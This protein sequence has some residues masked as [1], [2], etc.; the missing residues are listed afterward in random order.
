MPTPAGGAGL[1]KA[2]PMS[3][4]DPGLP[5][6]VSISPAKLWVAAGPTVKSKIPLFTGPP[7]SSVWRRA[8]LTSVACTSVVRKTTFLTLSR[9]YLSSCWRWAS[10]PSQRSYGSA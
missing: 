4:P 3:L 8:S 2:L 5:V 1:K 9:R 10:K 7:D 6:A